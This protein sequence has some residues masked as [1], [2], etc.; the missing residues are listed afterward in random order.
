MKNEQ[1]LFS[2]PLETLEPIFK[3]WVRE[4]VIAEIKPD[5]ISEKDAFH[6]EYI[7]KTE[8]KG[9][10]GIKSDATFFQ[11]EKQ[12]LITAKDKLKVGKRV[13]Y[14]R[15]ALLSAFSKLAKTNQL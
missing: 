12:G 7:S 15:A 13:F 10:Y 3:S 9:E 5:K 8:A 6:I 4:V 11:Y 14:K 1:V 2:I